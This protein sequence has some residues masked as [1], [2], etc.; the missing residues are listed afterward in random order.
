[1][2]KCDICEVNCTTNMQGKKIVECGSTSVV[3]VRPES[4]QKKVSGHGRT[5]GRMNNRWAKMLHI[6]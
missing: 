4:E 2:Q 6:E 5:S 1:M 3:K